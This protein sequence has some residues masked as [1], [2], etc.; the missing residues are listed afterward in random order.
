MAAAIAA[1]DPLDAVRVVLQGPLGMTHQCATRFVNTAGIASMNDFMILQPTDAKD[2]IKRH[3]E[4]HS[5]TQLRQYQLGIT[6]QKKFEGFLYWYH[7]KRRRQQLVVAAEFT[8]A[9]MIESMEK[10]RTESVAK[11]TEQK[12]LHPGKIETGS[13]WFGWSERA[14]SALIAMIGCSG[15]GPLYRVIREDRPPGWVPPNDTMR[16]CYELPLNGI[17]Y[18]LDNRQVWHLLQRWSPLRTQSIIGSK[19]LR[20]LRT[21]VARGVPSRTNWRGPHLSMHV[22]MRHVESSGM[23]RV[24]PNGPRNTGE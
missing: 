17:A 2:T 16:L 15:Q 8:E 13:G 6:Y 24:P 21:D 4:A 19:Y 3:N 11:E 20:Q 7:D 22:Q 14:E 18:D 5:T 23:V 10:G 1:V 9:M 12:D